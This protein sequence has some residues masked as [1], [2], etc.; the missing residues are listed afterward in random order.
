EIYEISDI[1][2][3]LQEGI[4]NI[5]L[6]AWGDYPP[7]PD[8]ADR[9][10]PLQDSEIA[11]FCYLKSAVIAGIGEKAWHDFRKKTS[12]KLAGEKVELPKDPSEVIAKPRPAHKV[13]SE[14]D[15]W[16][17]SLFSVRCENYR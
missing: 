3:R 14:L 15:I 17:R 8:A 16:N 5:V 4:Q 1:K 12:E 11:L 9:F 2:N 6:L 13:L 7:G 10:G